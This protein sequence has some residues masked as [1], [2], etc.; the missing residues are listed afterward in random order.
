MADLSPSTNAPVTAAAIVSAVGLCLAA[1]TEFTPEQVA[2]VNAVVAIIAGL[3]LQ[4]FHT[5]PKP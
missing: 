5:D 4:R 3:V 1:F 2:A